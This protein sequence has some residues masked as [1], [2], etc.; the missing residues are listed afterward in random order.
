MR[1]TSLSRNASVIPPKHSVNDRDVARVVDAFVWGEFD[2]TPSIVARDTRDMIGVVSPQRLAQPQATGTL[3]ARRQSALPVPI[4]Q[5]YPAH[6]RGPPSIPCL[7]HS[8]S[9]GDQPCR[10]KPPPDLIPWSLASRCPPP[11]GL[12]GG[13]WGPP[14]A[15]APGGGRVVVW[16]PPHP[17]ADLDPRGRQTSRNPAQGPNFSGFLTPA[18][19]SPGGVG[20]L[21]PLP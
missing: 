18:V 12:S 11:G 8:A 10:L 9:G 15:R 20:G 1:F 16:S 6:L 7:A 5:L 13:V 14:P 19:Q 2:F 4:R 21:R 17:P 3:G